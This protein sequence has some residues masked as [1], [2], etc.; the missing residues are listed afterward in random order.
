MKKWGV[1]MLKTNEIKKAVQWLK[2]LYPDA[3]PELVYNTAYELLVAVI[4]SAQCTDIRVNQVTQI[5]FQKYSTAQQMILLDEEE[6]GEIIRSTGLYK[7]K[8]K[9]ILETSRILVEKYGG[10]V[11]GE[12]EALEALP[13]VGRKTANVV[14][15]V[16]FDI[17][18][19]AVD[20][21]VFRVS[22]RLGIAEAK[23]VKQTENQLMKNI[24]EKDW[25]K[26]HHC[27][28]FHGRR[29]CKARGPLCEECKLNQ[30]CQYYKG[31]R[32]GKDEIN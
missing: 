9:N 1:N 29:I 28:I 17:P 3:K 7:A 13:G 14:L 11:P 26:M 32:G 6:L 30:I 5:L 27:L 24:A 22:N 4:L 12:R 10:E 21:H 19:I 23:D 20:T 31:L 15:S 25:Y 8:T 2:E 16:W 18:A